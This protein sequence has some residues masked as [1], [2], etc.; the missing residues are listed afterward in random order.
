MNL[1]PSYLSD[2][3]IEWREGAPHFLVRGMLLLVKRGGAFKPRVLLVGDVNEGLSSHGGC[4]HFAHEKGDILAHSDALVESFAAITARE[5][6]PEPEANRDVHTEHCCIAH[7]CK[8]GDDEECTVAS[9]K[10]GQSYPCI[11]CA[12]A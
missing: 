11:T 5:Y 4:G 12:G 3:R 9:G 1:L 10:K 2:I 6:H 8:Y 7:G